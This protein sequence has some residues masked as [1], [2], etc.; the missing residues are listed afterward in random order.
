MLWTLGYKYILKLLFLFSWG[1]HSEMKLLDHMTV[2]FLIFWGNSTLFSIVAAP[3]SIPSNS[4]QVF[5]FLHIFASTYLLFVC[6]FVMVILT[7]V[8]WWLVVLIICISLMISDVGHF[9]HVPVGLMNGPFSKQKCL[10][11]EIWLS[12]FP[13]WQSLVHTLYPSWGNHF[14]FKNDWKIHLIYW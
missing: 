8:R 9:F 10:S 4:V 13:D 2:L 7:D 1:K 6:L 3:I 12:E 11:L 14:P 5:P